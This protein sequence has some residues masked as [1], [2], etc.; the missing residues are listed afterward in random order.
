MPSSVAAATSML[1][2][3]IVIDVDGAKLR[4]GGEHVAI[5]LVVQ[6][7]EQDVALA[8]GRDSARLPVI[9]L[10]SGLTLTVATVRRRLSALSAI[11]WV[12]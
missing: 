1:S 5:D 10:A 8:R 2:G 4:I 9:R 6:P 11:G 7:A 12:T 3:V